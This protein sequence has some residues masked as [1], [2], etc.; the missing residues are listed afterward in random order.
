VRRRGATALHAG[1]GEWVGKA[2]LPSRETWEEEGCGL[3]D[4][5]FF[6]RKGGGGGRGGEGGRA[7][8]CGVAR[9]NF[10]GWLA[11]WIDG[12][13]VA[14]RRRYTREVASGWAKRR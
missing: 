2:A 3:R 14:V 9:L 13:G 6:E 4:A 10:L 7:L 11:G 1:G 12:C 8:A 5:H